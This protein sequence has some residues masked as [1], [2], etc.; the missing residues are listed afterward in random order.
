[1]KFIYKFERVITEMI[2]IVDFDGCYVRNDFFAEQFVRKAIENPFFA[3]SHFLFRKRTLLE[4]KELLLE[5]FTINY[6]I[7]QLVNSSV[8]EFIGQNRNRYSRVVLV[9]ASPEEFVRRILSGTQVFD[10]IHGS[11]TV[12]LKGLEKLSFIKAQFGSNFHYIGNSSDDDVILK[13]AAKGYKVTNHKLLE[14]A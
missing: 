13:A 4:T 6:P 3:M 2:L 9:S 1:V 11:T 8:H 12:N 14:Y 7:E 10:E 5:D